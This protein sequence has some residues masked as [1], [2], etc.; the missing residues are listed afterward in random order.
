MCTHELVFRSNPYVYKIKWRQVSSK[1]TPQAGHR[2]RAWPLASGMFRFFHLVPQMNTFKSGMV[3]FWSFSR[4]FKK[5]LLSVLGLISA[6][7]CGCAVSAKGKANAPP[8]LTAGLA[9]T[10]TVSG[11][12][13]S[14]ESTDSGCWGLTTGKVLLKGDSGQGV[15]VGALGPLSLGWAQE[16]A[17]HSRPRCRERWHG[18]LGLV[19]ACVCVCVCV[20]MNLQMKSWSTIVVLACEKI[21]QRFFKEVHF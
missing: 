5:S 9:L 3:L 2:A 6:A 1:V 13:S 11:S 21:A 15:V 4:E 19:L 20:T 17:G 18:L 10:R 12:H 7:K 14:S 16:D 8:G